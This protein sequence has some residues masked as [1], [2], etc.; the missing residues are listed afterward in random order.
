MKIINSFFIFIFQ[1]KILNSYQNNINNNFLKK[2]I[3]KKYKTHESL[4][5]KKSKQILLNNKDK[6][7]IYG[8]KNL[9]LNCEHIWCQKYFNY[10]EPMKSDLYNIYLSNSKL[11]SHRQDYKFCNIDKN[12]IFIN[13]EG[14]TVV[15]N[16]FNKLNSNKLNKKNNYKKLFEPCNS[17]KGKITRSIAY[18]NSIYNDTKNLEKIIDYNDMINW[19]RE[20]LPSFNEIKRNEFIRIHQK[21]INPFIKYPIL[22]EILYSKKFSPNNFLKLSLYSLITIIISDIIKIN[23]I[24]KK[25]IVKD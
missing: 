15:N 20:Y 14:N 17:S 12:F 8:N 2:L 24:L 6:N 22:V 18:F 10:K 5:Y 16:F 7:I 9:N 1:F 25:N 13:N 4:G 23:Y 3:K 21:N 11:N 19:N